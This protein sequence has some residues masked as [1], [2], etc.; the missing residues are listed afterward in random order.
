MEVIKKI[1]FFSPPTHRIS[2]CKKI[3]FHEIID[4]SFYHT[5]QKISNVKHKLEIN[6]WELKYLYYLTGKH[7]FNTQYELSH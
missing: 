2:L 1:V 6:V 3:K 4:F 5:V 7:K